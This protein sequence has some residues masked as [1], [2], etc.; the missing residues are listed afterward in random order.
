MLSKLEKMS[1]EI[2]RGYATD[3]DLHFLKDYMDSFSLR[4]SAYNKI[5]ELEK[6]IVEQVE[7]KLNKIDPNLLNTGDKDVSGKW[8]RDTFRAL[9]H[10]AITVLIDDPDRLKD[11]FLTWYQTIMQ[12]FGAEKSCN[13]TY[14]VMQDVV[15]RV[16]P[17][18]EAKLLRS[19][20]ELNRS[21]LG[22]VPRS[23]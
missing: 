3:E 4:L 2:E 11:Q 18:S 21:I 17:P 19:V 7:A 6:E 22:S 20:L 9:R 23:T 10:S 5:R 1:V 15:E 13:A 12:A 14:S 8:R 16:L